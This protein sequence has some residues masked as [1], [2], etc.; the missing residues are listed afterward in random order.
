MKDIHFLYI[1]N[2]VF[3]TTK[4]IKKEKSNLKKK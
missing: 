3:T 1:V 4:L 2:E